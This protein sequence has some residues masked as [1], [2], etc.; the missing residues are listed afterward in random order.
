MGLIL[1]DF[2]LLFEAL[3]Q[4]YNSSY[5]FLG[6]MVWLLDG[7]ELDPVISGSYALQH[8]VYSKALWFG[9]HLN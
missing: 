9:L 7:T 2:A 3:S 6:A 5:C 4:A 8:V 1:E